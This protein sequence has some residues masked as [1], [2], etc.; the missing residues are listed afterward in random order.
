[1][2]ADVRQLADR[3]FALLRQDPRHPSLHLK[4][5]GQFWSV[6]VGLHCRALAVGAGHDLVWV[7]IGSHAEYD[8]LINGAG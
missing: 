2:P 4:K 6:R 3:C 5:V 7:W 8:R 1:L